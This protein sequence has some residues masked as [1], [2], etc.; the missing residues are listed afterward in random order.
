[1]SISDSVLLVEGENDE[2]VVSHN[3]NVMGEYLNSKLR[4]WLE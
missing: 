3:A 1:M 4:I 2:H